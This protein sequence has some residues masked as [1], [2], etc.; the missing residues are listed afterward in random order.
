MVANVELQSGLPQKLEPTSGVPDTSALTGT[1]PT[2]AEKL[3]GLPTPVINNDLGGAGTDV[4]VNPAIV[5]EDTPANVVTT[6]TQNFAPYGRQIY[7]AAKEAWIYDPDPDFDPKAGYDE[8]VKQHNILSIEEQNQL[9]SAQSKEAQQDRL[10]EILDLRDAQKSMGDNFGTGLVASIFDLDLPISLVGGGVGIGAKALGATR[11]AQR[12]VAAASAGALSLGAVQA[13]DGRSMLTDTEHAIYA[14]ASAVGGAFSIGKAK[15]PQVT[16]NP[17][18]IVGASTLDAADNAIGNVVRPST[19]DNTVDDVVEEVVPEVV[20][21]KPFENY[22]VSEQLNVGKGSL[23]VVDKDTGLQ[24]K[25]KVSDD[26]VTFD[27]IKVPTGAAA[28]DTMLD[29]YRY[30]VQK[31]QD[32][33]KT[34]TYNGTDSLTNRVVKQLADEGYEVQSGTIKGSKV[35]K[36]GTIVTTGAKPS[37]VRLSEEQLNEL[38]EE[39]LQQMSKPTEDTIAQVDIDGAKINFTLSNDADMA[40]KARKAWST[41][42]P[43]IA[44]LQSSFDTLMY[45]AKGDLSNPITRILPSAAYTLGDDAGSAAHAIMTNGSRMLIDTET[46]VEKATKEL[47]GTS[48]LLGRIIGKSHTKHQQEVFMEAYKDIQRLDTEVLRALD[49]GKTLTDDEILKILDSYSTPEPIKNVTREYL[50]SGY[51]G[52]MY[53]QMKLR[54]LLDEDSLKGLPRR[55]TYMPV[56]HNGEQI[57]KLIGKDAARKA[58]VAKFLGEQI[59]KTYPMLTKGITRLDGTVIRMDAEKLGDRFIDNAIARMDNPAAVRTTG[60]ARNELHDIMTAHGIPEE[61]ASQLVLAVAQKRTAKH[62]AVN[63][64][65]RIVWDWS[66]KGVFKDGTEFNMSSLIDPHQFSKLNEY[67]RRMSKRIGLAKYGFKDRAS[68]D[69]AKH[70]L[71]DN[72]PEGVNRTTAAKDIDDIINMA[73]GNPVGDR[74]PEAMR[75][76]QTAASSFLLAWSG[77]YNMVEAGVQVAQVGLLRSAPH[78]VSAMRPMLL[79]MKAYTPKEA[80]KLLEALTGLGMDEGRWLNI[81]THYSDDFNVANSFHEGVQYAGQSARFLNGSEFVKRWQIGQYANVVARTFE[82]AAKGVASDV[83]FLKE[84]M[85]MSDELVND[86]TTEFNKH[87]DNINQWDTRVR[88]DMEQKV[89]H[90]MGNHAMSMRQ[91]EIPPFMEQTSWGKMVFP[92]MSFVWVAHN[93]LLRRTWVRDGALAAAMVLAVQFPLAVMV[94]NLK[95][96]VQGEEPY[97]MDDPKEFKE[98]LGSLTASMSGLGVFSIPMDIILSEGR[99]IGSVAA[100]AP[101]TKTMALAQAAMSED[102]ASFRDVKENTPL[103]IVAPVN[104]VMAI[105]KEEFDDAD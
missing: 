21:L 51:A 54:G 31:A 56:K 76:L 102:G 101:I 36:D 47:Y 14:V 1:K 67:N 50:K 25:Y 42:F 100:F 20:T 9:L 55:S 12:G 62:G 66:K 58:T 73:I 85:R 97:D 6:F 91:G 65:P 93:K 74:V 33:G 57:Y 96:R 4:P 34:F 68:L 87:G 7:R 82:N 32:L 94:S 26:A 63:L 18:D 30:G 40:E 84:N 24:A 86:I 44:K 78:L 17:D 98:F 5:P 15:P 38:V 10:N 70:Q 104:A 11:A 99:N 105:W 37:T 59:L 22:N 28:Y 16:H 8:I 79:G 77:L 80:E 83:K 53:D 13:A 27:G 72:L 92:F 90:E 29:A 39:E 81:F 69:E 2:K 43:M 61:E 23:R 3:S 46:A 103:N 49:D 89:L 64:R 95:R 48:G 45:Y 71:L 60:V 52:Y 41:K 88:V 19:T 35:S 75:A